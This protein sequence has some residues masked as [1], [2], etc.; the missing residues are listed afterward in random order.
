M[1]EHEKKVRLEHID[2][3]LEE[4]DKIIDTMNKKGYSNEKIN[5]FNKQRWNLWNERYRLKQ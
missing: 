4:L 3:A 1:D 2:M 5:E